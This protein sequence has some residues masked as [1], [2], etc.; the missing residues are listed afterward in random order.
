V[1]QAASL[2]AAALDEGID[3]VPFGSKTRPILKAD[4]GSPQ[5]HYA[6]AVAAFGAGSA[7]ARVHPAVLLHLMGRHRSVDPDQWQSAAPLEGLDS[8]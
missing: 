8:A 5:G 6:K 7:S 2:N 3:V 1:L 4:R